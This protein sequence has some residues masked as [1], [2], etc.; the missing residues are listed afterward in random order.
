MIDPYYS[1]K[2]RYYP[3]NLYNKLTM[4]FLAN[5]YKSL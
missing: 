1:N 3:V 4:D 5:P 2:M